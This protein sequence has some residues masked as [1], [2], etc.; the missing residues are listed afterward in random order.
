MPM[1]NGRVSAPIRD[2]MD[3]PGIGRVIFITGSFQQKFNTRTAAL[4]NKGRHGFDIY[5]STQNGNEIHVIKRGCEEL[6][7]VVVDLTEE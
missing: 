5:T 6:P 7:A 4:N 1:N 2:M 3:N